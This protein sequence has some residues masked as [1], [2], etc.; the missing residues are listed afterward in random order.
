MLGGHSSLLLRRRGRSRLADRNVIDRR[1]RNGKVGHIDIVA[2]FNW[3]IPAG[4]LSKLGV[5]FSLL[6]VKSTLLLHLHVCAKSHRSLHAL[7]FP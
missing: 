6:P 7:K 3:C 4:S 5:M 1:E 2:C